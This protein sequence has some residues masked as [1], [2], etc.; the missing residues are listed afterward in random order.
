MKFQVAVVEPEGYRYAH[1][2]YDI[3]RLLAGTIEDLGHDCTIAKNNL[4]PD[5]VNIIVGAHLVRTAREVQEIMASGVDYVVY[6]SEIINPDGVNTSGNT[7]RLEDVYLPLLRGA[8]AV[9]EGTETNIPSLAA[10]GIGATWLEPGHHRCLREIT[11][12][13]TRDID[14]LFYGSITPHRAAVFDG[15]RKRGHTVA[16]AFDPTW[17]FRNDLIA[18]TRVHLV[19]RQSL[20][21]N[22]LPY[23]R[24]VYQLHNRCVTVVE[25]CGH[26]AWLQDCFLWAN[27]ADYEELCHQTLLRPDR[28]K[29]AAGFHDAFARRPMTDRLGPL[30]EE[31]AGR[32]A[33]GPSH[34]ILT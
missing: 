20:T 10:H 33:R 5:R 3:V 15:L 11:H 32:C 24:I 17:M 31:V 26:Q 30:V 6:Q 29:V 18:R 22:Q 25:E 2:L 27:S 12:K 23:W 9:W 13:R 16:T 28:N 7:R 19:P 21:M 1:F 4:D 8:R 14:F 34:L